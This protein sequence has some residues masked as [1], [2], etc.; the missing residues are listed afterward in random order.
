[1]K[2]SLS[3]GIFFI[4][5]LNLFAQLPCIQWQKSLGG[6]GTDN[7]AAIRQTTDGGYIFAS[8]TNSNDGNV[9]GNH[10]LTDIWVVKLNSTGTIIWQRCLGGS[11]TELAH[12]IRQ[13]T[14]GGYVVAG[15]TQS[16]DGDVTGNHG[17]MDG[18]IVKLDANGNI[19]WQKTLGNGTYD[20]SNAIQQTTDGGYIVAGH[21]DGGYIPG[22][23]NIGTEAWLAKLDAGGNISWQKVFG[24]SQSDGFYSVYQT[25]DGGYV[26]SNVTNSPDGDVTGYHGNGDVFIV[27]VNSAGTVQWIKTLGGSASD[28][29]NS[30]QQTLDGG[31]IVSASTESNNGDV[32]SNHGGTDIWA[33]KL[34]SSG[35]IVWQKSIGGTGNE[36]AG[37]LQDSN[38]EYVLSASTNSNNGDVSG[39]HGMDDGWV[40]K[41]D[42]TGNILW[43][44]TFGGSNADG[45][46]LQLT[47]NAGYIL[48]GS[49]ASN[50]GDVSGNHGGNDVWVVKLAT[51]ASLELCNGID[52]NC[53]GLIDNIAVTTNGGSGLAATYPTLAAAITA[54]NAASITSPVVISQNGPE[55]APAGG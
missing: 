30:I 46:S 55:T 21:V 44:K 35:T 38:G 27:K 26:A 52:D 18:W 7:L 40:A 49:S 51:P 31:Y 36:G 41:L 14:D 33:I 15:R 9:S 3:L 39:N 50:Y 23:H 19:S 24:G 48:G 11:N 20:A 54:L 29:S 2:K 8:T 25:S 42:V 47:T 4:L 5:T 16:N 22:A 53:D 1:M 10:G 34:N 12:D 32:T 13:T 28:Y 45:V 43:Q 6:T 37:I 17:S